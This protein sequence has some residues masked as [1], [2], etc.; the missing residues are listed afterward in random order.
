MSLVSVLSELENPDVDLQ[1][2]ELVDT[3]KEG[4]LNKGDI[5]YG[6]CYESS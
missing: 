1:T 3:N 2:Q 6:M 4:Q 5:S